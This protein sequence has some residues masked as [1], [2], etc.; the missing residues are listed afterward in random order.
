MVIIMNENLKATNNQEDKNK[1]TFEKKY[2][3]CNSTNCTNFKYALLVIA[4]SIILIATN[5]FSNKYFDYKEKNPPLYDN[6][7]VVTIDHHNARK[8]MNEFFHDDISYFS[9]SLFNQLN[10]SMLKSHF[11]FQDM[12]ANHNIQSQRSHITASENNY[13][14]TFEVPGF[15]KEQINIELIANVLIVKADNNNQDNR[16]QLQYKS[17][18]T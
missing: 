9:D 4:A 5:I 2:T 18:T 13:I 11:A 7:P 1:S 12:L 6:T 16:N 15:T 10:T 17:I 8:Q 14:V 3:K